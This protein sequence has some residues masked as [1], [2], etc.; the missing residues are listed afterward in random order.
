MN[1]IFN[2]SCAVGVVCVCVCAHLAAEQV[3]LNGG[4]LC[5]HE[6]DCTSR[7]KT[8]LGTSTVWKDTFDLN[9]VAFM[10]NASA[11]PFRLWNQV[12]VPYCTG[13]MHRSAPR[14]R[15]RR[16]FCVFVCVHERKKVSD[17]RGQHALNTVFILPFV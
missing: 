9:S 3:V 4:G 7:A 13:D 17:F 5:T 14:T 15:T 11:N 10:S 1:Q 8:D 16:C 6:S 2:R 12:F